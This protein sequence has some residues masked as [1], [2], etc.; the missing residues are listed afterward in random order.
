MLSSQLEVGME[1]DNGEVS[2][3]DVLEEDEMGH[4]FLMGSR[5]RRN[6]RQENHGS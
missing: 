1:R 5:K 3:D 6:E 4:W 2:D